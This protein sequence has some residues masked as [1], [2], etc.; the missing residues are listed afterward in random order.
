[1]MILPQSSGPEPCIVRPLLQVTLTNPEGRHVAAVPTLVYLPHCELELTEQLLAAN[2]AAGS[3]AN[4]A[5]LGN[6]FEQYRERYE[7]LGGYGWKKDPPPAAQQQ[8]GGQRQ[9]QRGNGGGAALGSAQ[10]QRES[11]E[12]DAA[13]LE[14]PVGLLCDLCRCGAVE[15]RAVGER[16]F[17]IT[18]AFNDMSLHTFMGDW[19]ERLA[20]QRAQ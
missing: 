14:R 12:G 16:G 4:L 19:R 7:V 1:M 18:S 11:E 15:E 6:S 10:L 13:A 9:R 5:I 2:V 17:P 3:L 20:R 8:Q